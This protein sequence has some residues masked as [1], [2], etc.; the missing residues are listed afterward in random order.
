VAGETL[1][2]TD[3]GPVTADIAA[4]LDTIVHLF[5]LFV[6]P[7]AD[8]L[9]RLPLPGNRRFQR[10]RARL[11]EVVYRIIAERRRSG[12]DRG[13]LLSMLLLATDEDGGSGMTDEQLRDEVMTLILAG[14]ETTAN[15]LSWTFHLLGASPEVEARLHAE[16]DSVLQGRRPTADDVPR[17]T[18]T[19][20]V[21]AESMRLYPPAWSL[22]RRALIE[23][24]L[25]G[26]RIPKGSLVLMSP[27]VT[28]RDARWFPDPERFDP[29]RWTPDRRAA[30]PR[31]SYFPFGGGARSCIGEPFA[32][33]EGV[34]LV[35]TLAQAW[36][37]R[38]LPG[39]VV[40]PE[41][42]IT[43][44]PRGGM[45]MRFERRS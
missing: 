17:L 11:D 2:G 15:A 22:G 21:V 14:H 28:Q 10:A 37:L 40:R 36:R 4:A 18:Y 44:R 19:E 1:F 12:G 9:Q 6:L 23:L 34:L 3:T 29:G 8:V 16:V 25:D 42:L 38:P 24:S 35:S 7:F 41:A 43:L 32:W 5:P 26:W 33:L 27:Y 31:F 20:A 13:D 39:Q 45:P 30:R